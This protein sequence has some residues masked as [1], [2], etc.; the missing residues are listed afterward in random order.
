[1]DLLHN[2]TGAVLMG[3]NLKNL[4]SDIYTRKNDVH[5][6]IKESAKK[7]SED[8]IPNQHDMICP[9]FLKKDSFKF[10]AYDCAI[11]KLSPIMVQ[12]SNRSPM[13]ARFSNPSPMMVHFSNH[14]PINEAFFQILRP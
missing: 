2:N 7:K 13:M 6:F 10:F 14:S 12:L 5:Y 8:V 4:R 9:D 3:L 11:P 1:M